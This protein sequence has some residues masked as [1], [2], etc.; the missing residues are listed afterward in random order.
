MMR[1]NK[2][3][4]TSVEH[5]CLNTEDAELWG[6]V[7]RSV[8]IHNSRQVSAS[9]SRPPRLPSPSKQKTVTSERLSTSAPNGKIKNY[10]P[11]STVPVLAKLVAARE[12]R[13]PRGQSHYQDRLDLHGMTQREAFEALQRFL[14]DAQA[15]NTRV[16]LIITGKGRQGSVTSWNEPAGSD[17]VLRRMVPQ[18]LESPSIRN[19]IH[20]F[21]RAALN[22]GGAGAL[23][24]QL[25]K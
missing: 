6:R 11:I 18:W 19:V 5:R 24:V 16:V 1:N 21:S 20:S 22:H 9:G 10:R 7:I 8:K 12:N 14:S 25:R 13:L 15:R 3:Y 17:G 2:N 23:Y 4:V